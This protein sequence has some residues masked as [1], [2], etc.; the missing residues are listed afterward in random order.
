VRDLETQGKLKAILSERLSSLSAHATSPDFAGRF[1][2][3]VRSSQ[4]STKARDAVELILRPG[5]AFEL[6]GPSL[7][8]Q[9]SRLE[10]EHTA[11]RAVTS[12]LSGDIDGLTAVASRRSSQLVE[13]THPH[14][15]LKG[16]KAQSREVEI[17]GNDWL[18]VAI[19]ETTFDGEHVLGADPIVVVLVREDKH[20]KA[21]CVCRDINAVTDVVPA[22]CRAVEHSGATTSAPPEPRLHGRRDGQQVSRDFPFLTWTVPDGE[23]PLQAQVFED[24]FG[25]TD[26]PGASWPEARLQVF[27]GEPR[28]GKANPFV[29]VIGSRMSWTV[30]TIGSGGQISV[31]PTA[32]FEVR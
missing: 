4:H 27:P 1:F 28:K 24:H 31:A 6:P 23:E 29:G 30:W 32:R 18:A 7:G 15:L 17:R 5:P 11:R 16:L 22:L 14:A 13:C 19:V 9:A 26:E 2:W 3:L 21:L 12:F 20:W 25:P 8:T 10:A